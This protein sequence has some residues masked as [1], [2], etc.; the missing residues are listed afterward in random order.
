MKEERRI[1]ESKVKKGRRRK[2]KKN[3]ARRKVGK[4]I[5]GEKTKKM[6]GKT[7]ER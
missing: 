2:R 6:R 1:K 4:G 3:G 7:S 5:Q